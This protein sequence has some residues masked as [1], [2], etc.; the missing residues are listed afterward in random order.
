MDYK[1]YYGKIDQDGEVPLLKFKTARKRTM[2]ILDKVFDSKGHKV[3][4]LVIDHALDHKSV[5]VFDKWF[6]VRFL[7]DR[8][9]SSPHWTF[10][11]HE[12]ESYQEAY[13]SCLDLQEEN[14]LCY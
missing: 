1:L 12:H 7:E 5:Y 13:K 8:S 11:L 14:K 10:S 9:F 6:C 3:F 4:V 2:F